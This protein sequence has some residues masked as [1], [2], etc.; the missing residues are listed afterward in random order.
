MTGANVKKIET[1]RTA[2]LLLRIYHRP[3]NNCFVS[4]LIR[5]DLKSRRQ[6]NEVASEGIDR[7]AFISGTDQQQRSGG[8]GAINKDRGLIDGPHCDNKLRRKGGHAKWRFS[9]PERK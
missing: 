2:I 6:D 3:R 5:T 1:A 7:V 8:S 9:A 4:A